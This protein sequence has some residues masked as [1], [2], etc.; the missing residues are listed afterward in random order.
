MKIKIDA[1]NLTI[2]LEDPNIL[3]AASDIP[4][5]IEGAVGL[6]AE[7]ATVWIFSV[8][9]GP[10]AFCAAISETEGVISGELSTKFDA[11]KTLFT[12]RRPDQRIPVV[13]A[14]EDINRPWGSSSVEMVNKPS[15]EDATMPIPTPNY[16]TREEL[17]AIGSLGPEATMDDIIEKVNEIQSV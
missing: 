2:S 7:T 9:G 16:V 10:L 1:S 6:D 17:A 4:F 15:L 14:V 13:I 12:G 5:T 11:V 8:S 3:C